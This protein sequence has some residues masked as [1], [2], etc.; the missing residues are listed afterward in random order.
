MKKLAGFEAPRR[1]VGIAR[2]SNAGSACPVGNIPKE[3]F[4]T[5]KCAN[6]RLGLADTAIACRR[7]LGGP[8]PPVCDLKLTVLKKRKRIGD[9][10]APGADSLLRYGGRE[11]R[12]ETGHCIVGT[13]H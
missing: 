1:I 9:P 8:G 4:V 11:F 10:L 3:T 12:F 7:N 6:F 5:G 2:G 13:L